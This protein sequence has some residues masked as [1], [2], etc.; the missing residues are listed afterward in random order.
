MPVIDVA[1]DKVAY[2]VDGEGPGLLLV[3]GTAGDS[4]TNWNLM[5]ERLAERWTVVR[6]D[7]SGAGAT[8]DDGTPLTV[9]RLVR[10]VLAAAEHAGVAPFHVLGF[11]LG[12]VV[13]V[14]LAADHPDKVRSLVP[15]GGILHADDSRFQ[16]QMRFWRTLVDRDRE[17]LARLWTLTAFSPAF[18]SGLGAQGV[19]EVVALNLEGNDWAGI[20][21]QIDLDMT[22]DIR[23]AAARVTSPALVI[24]CGQDQMLPPE[25]ARALSAQIAG[26]RYAEVDSGHAA[27]IEAPEAVLDLVM[28]FFQ[29]IEAR[30]GARPQAVI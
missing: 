28:P 20:G 1:G 11:S 9:A 6:P 10:Q 25:H 2:K 24:G 18:L 26:A 27:P 23:A 29:E 7:Y 12:A 15:L 19:E 3:H 8:R 5:V 4:E 22:I 14:Q 30:H 16:M 13:A 21:R 17:A